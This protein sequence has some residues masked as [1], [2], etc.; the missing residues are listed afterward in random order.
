MFESRLGFPCYTFT[1]KP[2]GFFSQKVGLI[3]EPPCCSPSTQS[4][5]ITFQA[6][7]CFYHTVSDQTHIIAILALVQGNIQLALHLENEL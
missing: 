6:V 1:N 7:A 5:V 4:T 2:I 3:N